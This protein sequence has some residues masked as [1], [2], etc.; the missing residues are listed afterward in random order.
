MKAGRYV[1]IVAGLLVAAAMPLS[2]FGKPDDKDGPKKDK[3]EARLEQRDD[4]EDRKKEKLE[5]KL[6]QRDE[7]SMDARL[8]KIAEQLE[9]L[10]GDVKKLKEREG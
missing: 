6:E 4:K 8:D 1:S 10:Q 7:K 2:A 9:R 5:G 3:P